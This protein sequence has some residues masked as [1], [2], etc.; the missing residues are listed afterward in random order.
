MKLCSVKHGRLNG[1]RV[2]GRIDMC[3]G[4][5]S[6]ASGKEPTWPMQAT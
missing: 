5:P 3:K 1:S 6:G 4:F 2:W